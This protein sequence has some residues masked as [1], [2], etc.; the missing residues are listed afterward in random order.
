MV[1]RI[2]NCIIKNK[3]EELF[4]LDEKNNLLVDKICAFFLALSPILQH[5]KGIFEDLGITVL[6]IT[7][8]W[9]FLKLLSIIHQVK[10]PAMIVGLLIFQFYKSVIHGVS[11]MGLAYAVVMIFIYI[12][13]TNDLI[14]LTFFLRTSCSIATLASILILVQYICYYVLGFH[15]QLVPT[16]LLL[17]E[18]EQWILGAQTG[19]AGITGRIG[20]L[21]RPS[22]FF[23]EPSHM[24]LYVF[25]HIFIMLLSPRKS[26]MKIRKGILLS[27]GVVLTTSGMGLLTVGFAWVLYFALSSG[28][29]NKLSLKNLLKPQNFFLLGFFLVAAIFAITTIPTIQESFMRI[30]DTSNQGAVAGRTRLST[31]LI[32]TLNFS[33]WVIGVTNTLEGIEFNMPGFL[34]TVYKFGLIGVFLSYTVYVYGIV[35]CKNAYFWTS[36]FVVI[37][38]FYSAQTHGTF[39]MMYYIFIILYSIKADE[40]SGNGANNS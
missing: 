14:N 4:A 22:A 31:N 19:L 28:K 8:L 23:L 34:A 6:L 24:F 32:K 7:C 21:Y 10:I 15:L 17:P 13:A 3:Y 29:M 36:V 26:K 30:I 20:T 12:T 38:S 5:Y 18:A 40:V 1:L 37:I 25:P 27:M 39:Y 35:K 2:G 11:F 9:Y 33:E 16:T